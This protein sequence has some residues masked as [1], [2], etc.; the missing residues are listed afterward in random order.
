MAEGSYSRFVNGCDWA[1]SCGNAYVPGETPAG[2]RSPT[3]PLRPRANHVAIAT[4]I[5]TILALDRRVGQS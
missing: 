2:R 1:V 5:E 4:K 3:R